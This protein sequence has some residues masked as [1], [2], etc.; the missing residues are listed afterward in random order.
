MSTI[1]SIR[2]QFSPIHPEGYPFVG[3]F[4]LVALILLWLWP[5]L[6]WL[7]VVVTLWCAYFFRDPQRVTPKREGILV[8]PAD[9]TVSRVVETVPPK[10]LA[11]GERPLTRIM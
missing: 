5:P 8:S 2:S 6:G 4:A 3:G 1:N 11:L 7:A 10:E 9:G